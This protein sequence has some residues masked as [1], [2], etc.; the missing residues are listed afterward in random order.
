MTLFPNA[1]KCQDARLKA[2]MV[3]EEIGNA[4]LVMEDALKTE[5]GLLYKRHLLHERRPGPDPKPEILTIH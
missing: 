3:P 5:Y 1:E 2:L 4:A